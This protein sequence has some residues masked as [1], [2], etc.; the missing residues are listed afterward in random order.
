[1]QPLVLR[2]RA[3]IHRGGGRGAARGGAGVGGDKPSMFMDVYAAFARN[4][5]QRYGTTKEQFG[6]IAVKNHY[7]GSLNPH[8]QYREVYTLED[9]LNSPLVAGPLT[10]P[11]RSPPGDGAG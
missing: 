5:M 3:L 8:A 4:H 9:V 6:R 2:H 7:H 1:M 11:V 10:P